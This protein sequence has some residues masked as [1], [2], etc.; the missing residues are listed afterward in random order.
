MASVLLLD[1]ISD[2]FERPMR[3]LTEMLDLTFVQSSQMVLIA[4]EFI[5]RV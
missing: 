1:G 5:L 3:F 2:V 4:I